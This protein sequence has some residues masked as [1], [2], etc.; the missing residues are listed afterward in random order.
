MRR[1]TIALMLA[2]LWS[3]GLIVAAAVAPAYESTSASSSVSVSGSGSPVTVTSPPQTHT[4][5]TLL[6][7]N[8]P[9]VLILIAIPLFAVGAVAAALRRRHRHERSGAGPF[10]WTVVGLLGA[11]AFVGMMTIGLFIL[12]VVGLLCFACGS[13]SAQAS[14]TPSIRE[15]RMSA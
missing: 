13:A 4:T 7:E 3:A 10:A 15:R 8:G 14:V 2:A 1:V 12:P 6:A 11:F 5:S 9:S